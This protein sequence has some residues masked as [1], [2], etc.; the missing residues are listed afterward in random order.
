[1]NRLS[2]E[3]RHVADCFAEQA[4]LGR[5]EIDVD[6]LAGFARYFRALASEAEA[7]PDAASR[8]PILLIVGRRT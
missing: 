2:D 8:P 1:M 6:E 3:L 5:T 7:R 4:A